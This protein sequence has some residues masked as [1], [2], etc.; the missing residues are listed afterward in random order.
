[1]VGIKNNI[2][3]SSHPRH[4][5]MH[6]YWG[7]KPHNVV[8]EYISQYTKENDVVL[9]PFM[10]SGVVIIEALKLNR[11]AYGVDLNP[12]SCFITKNTISKFNE[13]LL[14]KE[15]LRIYNNSFKKYSDLYNTKC[16]KCNSFSKFE[17][18]IWD[19]DV[20]K[21]VKGNCDNCGK[22]VKDADKK[23]KYQ[24]EKS[25]KL[26]NDLDK[27]NKLLY[28]KDEILKYVKRN[29]KT[30]INMLF[31]E[32]ALII[33]SSII[34][35]IKK[36]KDKS[37]KNLLLMVFTSMLP[38]VSK[39]IPGDLQTVNGRSGW[40][41]SKLWSPKIHTE[42]NIFNS[43]DFRFN[44]I[45]LGKKDID[46]S[47][48]PN[49]AYLFNKNSENL[50]FIKNDSIDY[51]F[52][53]PPYGDSIAYFALS[54]FWNS[55]LDGVVNYDDEIIYDPYRNKKYDDYGLRLKNV[56]KELYRVLKDKKYLSFTFHN[57][58]LNIWKVIM[59]AVL[60][61]GFHL[62]NIIYQEQA[63]SS[64]TQGLNKKNTLKGDFVYNFVKDTSKKSLKSKPHKD[65]DKLIVA[66]VNKWMF[67]KKDLLTP[68]KLYEKLIPLLVKNNAYTD[69][70][71]KVVNIEEILKKNFVYDNKIINGLMVYGWK[72]K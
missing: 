42:K 65:A 30:H 71:N 35:D 49:N 67:N 4:Y 32:R 64:G 44:K 70:E 40:V 20:I 5:L 23:D 50:S 55:W 24:F 19:R 57:R 17:N 7:R 8:S 31:S 22:F 28:P 72:K 46:G 59:D 68:D 16:P 66:N 27:K 9:D 36:V 2:K 45:L 15:F 1:M 3:A 60:D 54:M 29:G 48:D 62:Q 58:N 51:I 10:G 6:K 41:I 56:Y 69:S 18:S 13:K 43:F 12:I 26:F 47:M 34:V 61:A 37:T 11:K 14:I 21:R 33:L 39:M 25:V 38:N 63:V 52:T 53:D